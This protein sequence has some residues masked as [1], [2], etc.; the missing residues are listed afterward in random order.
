MREEY[1]YFFNPKARDEFLKAYKAFIT[2]FENNK[3][4]KVVRK[5]PNWKIEEGARLNGAGKT[6]QKK[7]SAYKPPST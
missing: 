5:T 6:P 3:T 2:E 4:K 1:H 7:N